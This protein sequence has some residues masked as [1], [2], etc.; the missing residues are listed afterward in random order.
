MNDKFNQVIDKIL[1]LEKNKLEL[2]VSLIIP[3]CFPPIDIR[4]FRSIESL[5][6]LTRTLNCLRAEGHFF[7]G[8]IV[9]NPSYKPKRSFI[10]KCDINNWLGDL[11]KTPNF[12]KHCYR[13]LLSRLNINGF[14][15]YI[16]CPIFFELKNNIEFMRKINNT[17]D[18]SEK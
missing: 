18:E 2:L 8:D 13:D 10:S 11:F 12:G 4:L 1:Q 3:D 14:T 17:L 15:S 9:C 16:D 6:L 7:I 5:D